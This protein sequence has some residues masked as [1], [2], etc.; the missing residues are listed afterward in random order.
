M[1]FTQ[2]QVDALRQLGMT[3]EAFVEHQQATALLKALHDDSSTGLELQ[4][5]VKRKFPTA[6][7]PTLDAISKTEELGSDLAKRF[8]EL[9]KGATEKI[10]KFLTDRAKE[11]ED[12]EVA[13]Y[14]SR[15]DKLMKDRGY[16]EDGQ[17]KVIE[18]MKT[19]NIRD[20]EDAVVLFEASQPKEKQ[21]TKPYSS[22]F[23]FVEKNG[24]DDESFNRLMADPDGWMMDEMY[25]SLGENNQE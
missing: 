22:R 7:T 18:L 15:F 4:K 5:L 17:K 9:S 1:P 19:K 3:P 12:A 24:K 2:E 14:Q 23:N 21:S 6:T 20:P 11:R 8:E 25:A 10:D 13:N 16:T